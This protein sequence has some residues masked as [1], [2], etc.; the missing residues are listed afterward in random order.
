MEHDPTVP[1]TQ[2]NAFR[3]TL[4]LSSGVSRIDKVLLEA[5]REQNRNLA[6]REISRTD[7]K[8]LFKKKK[9]LIKGQPATPSSAVAKGVTFVDI[10]GFGGAPITPSGS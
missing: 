2:P 3:I 9:I 4:E 10:L 6:L 8:E 5:I 7:Y 1:A